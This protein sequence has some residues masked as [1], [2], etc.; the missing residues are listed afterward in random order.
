M[1]WILRIKQYYSKQEKEEGT[2]KKTWWMQLTI[3]EWNDYWTLKFEKRKQIARKFWR[4][5][6]AER[7]TEI[8]R[9]WIN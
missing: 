2:S 1:H 5:L 7:I 3:L 4:I 8:G 9:D 6:V